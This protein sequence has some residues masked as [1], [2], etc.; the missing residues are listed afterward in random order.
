MG[1]RCTEV[2]EGIHQLTTRPDGGLMA[3]NQYLVEGDEPLLFHTG[4]RTMFPAVSEAVGRVLPP[5]TVRWISFGHVEG[6]ECGSMNEW[7][8]IAPQA[9]IAHSVIG[10]STSLDD[11]AA[12]PPRRLAN[13]ETIDIGGHVLRWIDT[14]H[15]PHSMDAGVMYDETT[16][17]L[18][19]G[20]LFTRWGDYEATSDDL[21]GPAIEAEDRYCIYSLHPTT[22][23]TVRGL[24]ELDIETL[25]P[26]HS[27]AFKGDCRQ[28]L[29]DLADDLD[30]RVA[31]LS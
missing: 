30:R 15:V 22:G 14:P 19:C 18:L 21:L 28:A 23:A 3:F 16:G 6:D 31:A 2:A 17:T 7:L 5:E 12:R 1:T 25:A 11:A 27:S 26:M 29:L 13:G 20:D 24:A 10:C 9:T 8:E 4:L